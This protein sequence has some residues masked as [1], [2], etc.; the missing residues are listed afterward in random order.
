MVLPSQMS[1]S[2]F[3]LMLPAWMA[4]GLLLSVSFTPGAREIFLKVSR[5]V[6][7][8]NTETSGHGLVRSHSATVDP[9]SVI[10]DENLFRGPIVGYSLDGDSN[11]PHMG[12]HF[13][14]SPY[15]AGRIPILDPELGFESSDSSSISSSV[16]SSP[17]VQYDT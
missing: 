13:D 12:A 8:L 2:D 4:V 14:D 1:T 15:H 7:S 17:L 5:F 10:S 3:V 11:L 6:S 9:G 16:S